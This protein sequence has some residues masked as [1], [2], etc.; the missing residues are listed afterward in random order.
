MQ[1]FANIK[2]IVSALPPELRNPII[3][4][5]IALIKPSVQSDIEKEWQEFLDTASTFNNPTNNQRIDTSVDI[6][7]NKEYIYIVTCLYEGYELKKIKSLMAEYCTLLDDF[8]RSIGSVGTP[9]KTDSDRFHVDLEKIINFYTHNK[10]EITKAQ[11][12]NEIDGYAQ[13]LFGEYYTPT[14][15][16]TSKRPKPRP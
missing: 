10:D 4:A 8:I 2:K 14:T 15:I 1:D 16:N 6:Y 9:Y 5:S 12:Q 7:H 13:K 11:V 3:N